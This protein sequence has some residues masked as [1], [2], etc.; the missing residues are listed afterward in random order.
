MLKFVSTIPISFLL[1]FC[2]LESLPGW[3]R[4]AK[5][6]CQCSPLDRQP[7]QADKKVIQQVKSEK[8]KCCGWFCFRLPSSYL[9][10]LTVVHLLSNLLRIVF[11]KT[12]LF[13]VATHLIFSWVGLG[14]DLHGV[15]VLRVLPLKQ[16]DVLL[17]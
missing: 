11:A 15:P 17:L 5:P 9:G 1:S 13:K 12:L 7:L 6:P 10:G 4:W 2:L 8:K 3:S 14:Q 16:I